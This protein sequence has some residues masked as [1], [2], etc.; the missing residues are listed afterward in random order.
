MVVVLAFGRGR[1]C[2]CVGGGAYFAGLLQGS[3]SVQA[4]SNGDVTCVTEGYALSGVATFATEGY[5]LS[6]T[7]VA[8]A[9]Q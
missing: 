5:A 6:A 8:A 1:P 9:V 2:C 7:S 4:D 3:A